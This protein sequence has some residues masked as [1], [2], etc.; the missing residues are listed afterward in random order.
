MREHTETFVIS[1]VSAQTICICLGVKERLPVLLVFS[2]LRV[3]RQ[4]PHD[5]IARVN[6]RHCYRLYS[7]LFSQISG[8]KASIEKWATQCERWGHA[9]PRGLGPFTSRM[10]WQSR[11]CIS[12]AI[13]VDHFLLYFSHWYFDWWFKRF[14][15]FLLIM[16]YGGFVIASGSH[17]TYIRTLYKKQAI[18]I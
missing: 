13:H 2:L 4:K 7:V 1:V 16:N 18:P 11:G 15:L 10:T 8:S 6:K 3:T 5:A 9:L 17:T 14:Y 12:V